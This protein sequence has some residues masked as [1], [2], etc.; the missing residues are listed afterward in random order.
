[1]PLFLQN[2]PDLLIFGTLAVLAVASALGML[3]S[4]HAVYAALFLVLNFISIAILFLVLGAPFVALAQ[5]TVYAG[6]IMVLFLF[7][8]ML[9]GS[10]SL[11]GKS[12]LRFHRSVAV[13]FGLA[14]LV[15][16]GVL[17]ITIWGDFPKTTGLSTV[18]ADPTSLGLALFNQYTLPFEITS[19]ILLVGIIGAISLILREHQTGQTSIPI[20]EATGEKKE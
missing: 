19:L 12:K 16:V 14:L 1:M 6:A 17:V 7:V 9:L 3:F 2:L 8:I 4:R 15:E 11:P 5:I 20:N 10:E 13:L 18:Y